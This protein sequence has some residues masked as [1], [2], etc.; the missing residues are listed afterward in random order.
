MG[1]QCSSC[2]QWHEERPTSF[3]FALPDV[4]AA[5]DHD[6]RLRRVDSGSEQCVLDDKHFFIL[7]NLDLRVV[8]TDEVI[9]WTAWS[10]LSEANFDRAS[11]L[12]TREGRDSEPPYSGW[13][14]NAI[15]G[16]ESTVNIRVLVH[17][18]RVGERP[19]LEVVEEVHPLRAG[20]LNGIS[21]QRADEL[22][23]AALFGVAG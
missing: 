10:T 6:Q 23:H 7:G 9:R 8:G 13:L 22:I 5:L 4:V 11:E 1:Y 16:F 19:R 12:W 18:N 17:T 21:Q 15:P 2:G 20:Q 3:K 14:S